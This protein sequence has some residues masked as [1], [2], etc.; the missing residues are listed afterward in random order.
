MVSLFYSTDINECTEWGYCD[1]GCQN[2]RPGFTCSCLGDCFDLEMMHGPGKD[3]L[4]MRGYCLSKNADKMR[5][6]IARREG[7]YRFAPQLMHYFWKNFPF[8]CF[9]TF[10]LLENETVL[11][12]GALGSFIQYKFLQDRSQ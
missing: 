7:L 4:T 3:N 11:I 2:H 1:Q 12:L 5:L 9:S 10:F 6:F 8:T